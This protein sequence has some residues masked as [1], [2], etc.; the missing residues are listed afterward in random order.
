MKLKAELSVA[1]LVARQLVLIMWVA[2]IALAAKQNELVLL[3]MQGKQT[4]DLSKGL[5]VM[6]ILP[7]H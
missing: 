6:C 5:A 1:F 7:S 3:S 2:N 4:D